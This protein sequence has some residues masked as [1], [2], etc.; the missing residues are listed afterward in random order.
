M[1]AP[2]GPWGDLD[3]TV[4]V[5]ALVAR[6]AATT[7][8]AVAVADA[9]GRW[10]YAELLAAADALATRL[11]RA[12]V[13]PGHRVG[14]HLPRRRA[15]VAALLA[16]LQLGAAYVL[17]DPTP[18]AE[19]LAL[20]TCDAAP[21]VLVHAA[22]TRADPAL[23]TPVLDVDEALT[24][25]PGS[26][27]PA[28]GAPAAATPDTPAYVLYTSGSTG[29]PKGVL[30]PH[31]GISGILQYARATFGL[32]PDDAVLALASPSV[33]FA[34]LEVLLPL[35]SGGTLHLLD[36]RPLQDPAELGAEVADR[37]ITFLM[38]TPSM[39]DT[40]TA[41]GWVPP[42][43]LTVLC[44][45]ETLRAATVVALAPARA[46]RNLY[47]P[48]ETSVFSTCCRV[49]PDDITPGTPVAGTT[50]RI[51]D[52]TTDAGDGSR[53]I[54]IG[55][56]GVALGYLGRPEPTR[57]KFVDDPLAPGRTLY[58]TGDL[59]LRRPDGR[60]DHR[61]RADD[62]VEIRGHRIEL[63]VHEDF[64]TIGGDSL[65][66]LRTAA[67]CRRAGLHLDPRAPYE[68]PTVA[69]LAARLRTEP[70]GP[71]PTTGAPPVPA[72]PEE[73]AALA[74]TA[75]LLPTQHR[76]FGRGFGEI[77][78]DNE[79]LLFAVDHCLDRTALAR[80]LTRLADRHPALTSR[81]VELA[82][83]CRVRPGDPA[84]AVPL[85]WHDHTGLDEAAADRAFTDT[86]R[87]LHHRL[88]LRE[89]PVCR[90]AYFRRDGGDRLL[91]LLHHLVCDGVTL[92]TL[93]EELSTLYRETAAGLD[94]T[95]GPPPP[96]ALGYA[97]ELQDL[98]DAL[99]RETPQLDAWLRLPWDGVRP[100]PTRA[101]D[102]GSL[103]RPH[104]RRT[105]RTSLEPRTARTVRTVARS[106]PYTTE[107]LLI[108]AVA[109][110][111][112]EFSGASAACLDVVRHGRLSPL[113]ASDLS[114]TV[115]SLSTITPFVLDTAAEGTPP[116][117]PSA[118]GA[119]PDLRAL[120]AQIG[121]LHAIEHVWGVLRHLH[122]DPAVTGRLAA[123]PK[124]EVYLDFRGTGLHDVPV[125]PPF[126]L[127]TGDTGVTRPPTHPQ[128]YPLEIRI[129][130]ADQ[131]LDLHWKFS[132]RRNA[133]DDVRRLARRC[134]E[135]LVRLAESAT[136]A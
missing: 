14:V 7:P 88:D 105:L 8:R 126:S 44:G 72:R 73:P 98:A 127:V 2:A 66:A 70:A 45:G 79:P 117:A 17:L 135:L 122:R 99:P 4:P 90:A 136:G 112:A 75:P 25:A 94:D 82:G 29:R 60:I 129:D 36:R 1:S 77:G 38:G 43:R 87:R 24:T 53:E 41:T 34:A 61:G 42:R 80:C 50:V 104:L 9:T 69:R 40:L 102:P 46:V 21:T 56:T 12:G 63:G 132:L 76:F 124:P 134:T 116:G 106:S 64:F 85:E 18:P 118:A 130:V 15:L 58:H 35:V 86:A 3:P 26:D 120:S 81:F 91:L 20:L 11:A 16:T 57:E 114:R 30:L 84:V 39:F 113:T 28:P 19:R 101:E 54:C 125:G 131:R 47:G 62:Q 92:H 107:D 27:P 95:L 100:F 123:L 110:G 111:V 67:R 119:L 78:H 48:T 128:P 109:R 52:G 13:G 108:A 37:G 65:S 10:T 97:R 55:G 103:A 96:S 5:H 33:D 89:G 23:N 51:L 49:T 68:A 59:G 6:Q 74:G 133:E 71:P 32:R 83:E 22:E 31:R 115:G 93:A 121:R